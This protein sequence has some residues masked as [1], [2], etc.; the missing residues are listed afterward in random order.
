MREE[1]MSEK[2]KSEDMKREISRIS[3]RHNF[4]RNSKDE[5]DILVS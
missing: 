1:L 5:Q 2:R 4:G 3:C